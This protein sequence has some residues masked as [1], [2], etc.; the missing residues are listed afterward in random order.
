MT[1]T[2]RVLYWFPLSGHAHRAELMLRFL[3]LDFDVKTVDLAKGEQKDPA[4]L[5]LNPLGTVPTLDDG[6]VIVADSTAILVYLATR[7]DPA[8][9]WLPTDPKLA[10]EVQF[11]LSAAQ[12]PVYN[13][14]N[15]ARVLKLFKR[16]GDHGAAVAIA[17]RFLPMLDGQLAAR[18]FLVA[19]QPTIADVAIYSYVAHAPEG[20]VSLEPYPHIRAWLERVEALPGFRPMIS[21]AEAG[22]AA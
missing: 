20:D 5:E 3:G 6:G 1:N 16:P 18:R 10:S 8:R 11:W 21:A 12:G 15:M 9:R 13:G 2:S 22:L 7:Y 4:Y 14:P 17:G 19:D